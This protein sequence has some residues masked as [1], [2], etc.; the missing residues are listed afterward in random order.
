MY[1][2]GWGDLDGD[3]ELWVVDCLVGEVGDFGFWGVF[4]GCVY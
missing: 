2:D 1:F 3:V 4:G